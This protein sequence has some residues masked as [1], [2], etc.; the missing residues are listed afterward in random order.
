MP[1]SGGGKGM[2]KKAMI[3]VLIHCKNKSKA[4]PWSNELAV[5]RYSFFQIK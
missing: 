4:K 2:P 5:T 1:K 3:S